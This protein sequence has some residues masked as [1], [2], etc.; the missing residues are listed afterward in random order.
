[1]R[2]IRCARHDQ[3]QNLF[4]FQYGDNIYYRAYKDIN[5]GTELLV[6]YDDQYEKFFGVP[7]RLGSM[8]LDLPGMIFIQSDIVPTSSQFKPNIL[9]ANSTFTLH[10][11]MFSFIQKVLGLEPKKV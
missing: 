2:F 9:S 8:N 11:P 1:M 10:S 6:W 4:A 5:P 7:I 3:E